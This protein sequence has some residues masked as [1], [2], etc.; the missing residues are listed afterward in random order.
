MDDTATV[1]V[2][3]KCGHANE[4]TVRRCAHCGAHL[5]IVCRKCGATNERTDDSCTN[6][7]AR[8]H[9]S[10]LQ[11]IKARLRRRIKWHEV[12]LILAGFVVLIV[13]VVHIARLKTNPPA[14]STPGDPTVQWH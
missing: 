14:P 12:A 4:T 1:R 2:C 3:V 10:V 7:G 8:L 13:L 11:R 5:Q 6:C 9:R